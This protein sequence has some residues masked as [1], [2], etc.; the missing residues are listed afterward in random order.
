MFLLGVAQ[1][2]PALA[3]IIA[4]S[5]PAQRG[6]SWFEASGAWLR[7]DK[8]LAKGGVYRLGHSYL[9]HALG[10]ILLSILWGI[11]ITLLLLLFM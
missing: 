1:W 9:V 10:I 5:Y 6:R 3:V 8:Y 4:Y 2:S 11:T 7:S